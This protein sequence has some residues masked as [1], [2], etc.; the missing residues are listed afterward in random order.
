VAAIVLVAAASSMI[1]P[2]VAG[3]PLRARPGTVVRWPGWGIESCV[4]GGRTWAP[5]DGA[6][7][8]PIDLLQRAGPLELVRRRA[9]RR[10][11]A[12]VEVGP[13]D[14]P[15]QRLQMPR[16]WVELRP[17]D[18]ARV[19]RENREIA[20][21]WRR[22][23]P[24]QFDLPLHPPLDPLP[25]GGRFGDR[26]IINGSPRSP[27][28]GA[29]Y[30]ASEGTPVLAAA[31]GVVAMVAD[32]FFGGRSVFVDHGDGLITMYFHLSQVDV[33]EGQRLHAGDGLGRVG[34]TGR[35]MGPHLHFG[36]R[37]HGARIDPAAL[38]VSLEAIPAVE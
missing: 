15:V 33:A 27:H 9:G 26:R 7:L 16:G 24:R 14:Y 18:L 1:P 23:G 34:R 35:A 28:S 19:E 12:R 25:L 10:E 3:A 21:L 30:A 20:P 37:W 4:L 38:L 31:A 5:L 2:A 36:V 11:T 32:H 17:Q 29:D 8:F 6:C 13:Y 22:A